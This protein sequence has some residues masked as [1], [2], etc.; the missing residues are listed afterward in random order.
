VQNVECSMIMSK[1]V[2][3]KIKREYGCEDL[4]LPKYQTEG[5]AGMDLYAAVDGMVT[6]LPGTIQLIPTG[7]RISIPPGLEGQ[8]RPRSGLALK[9]GIGVLNS[10]GT[11]DSDYRGM[12]GVILFN[13]SG[14]GLMDLTGYDAYLSGKLTDYELPEEELQKYLVDLEALPKAEARKSGKW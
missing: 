14:H 5:S 12:V 11:I 9:H 2:E 10:P 13:F 6:L 1:P 8:V 7:I 4:P 3:I